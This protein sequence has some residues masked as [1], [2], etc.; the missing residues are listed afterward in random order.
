MRLTN[1]NGFHIESEIINVDT[2]KKVR[3]LL[4]DIMKTNA[5]I[6]IISAQQG[7]GKSFSAMNYMAT[8]PD[9]IMLTSKHNLLNEFETYF[10]N[11]NLDNKHWW[12]I[13]HKMS[14][15]LHKNDKMFRD[16]LSLGYSS[17]FICKEIFRCEYCPYKEQFVHKNRVL[18]PLQYLNTA[19]L[20]N[21]NNEGTFNTYIID[22]SITSVKEFPFDIEYLL[23]VINPLFIFGPTYFYDFLKKLLIDE[24]LKGLESSKDQILFGIDNALKN[25]HELIGEDENLETEI[26]KQD[27]SQLSKFNIDDIITSLKYKKMYNGDIEDWYQPTIYKVF[28]LAQSSKVILLHATFDEELFTDLLSSYAGEVGIKKEINVKIFYTKLQNKSTKVYDVNPGAYFPDFS[29]Q[30]GGLSKIKDHIEVITSILGSDNV[31]VLSFNKYNNKGDYIPE[32]FSTTGL[33]SLHWGNATGTN[34]LKDK[35]CLIAAGHYLHGDVVG[36]YNQIYLDKLNSDNCKSLKVEPGTP[37]TY[38][39]KT[40]PKLNLVQKILNEFEIKDGLH[41]S[42]GLIND[43]RIIIAF[44]SIPKQIYDEFEVIEDKKIELTDWKDLLKKPE[45]PTYDLVRDF[46]ESSGFNDLEIAEELD[47]DVEFVIRVRRHWNEGKEF[48]I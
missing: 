25:I 8:N 6:V 40:H 5:D 3:D 36:V 29:L 19:Y 28:D 43:N 11:H 31:G 14:P 18:A 17:S 37:F 44:C 27:I 9:S 15:C 35:Q 7:V 41:R 38:C 22:E 33:D 45:V 24:D 32:T 30:R 23:N 46:L 26:W 1:N 2:V 4:P 20:T 21:E 10:N 12:G 47:L 13:S 39:P 34:T 16:L 42:R 48:G